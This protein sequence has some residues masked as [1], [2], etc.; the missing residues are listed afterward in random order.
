MKKFV[1]QGAINIGH[2]E[3]VFIFEAV[4]I[5]ILFLFLTFFSI[6]GASSFLGHLHFEVLFILRSSSMQ[7]D[8]EV[9]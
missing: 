2:F 9:A 4:F 5:F 6:L 1:W 7:H 8:L 3:V